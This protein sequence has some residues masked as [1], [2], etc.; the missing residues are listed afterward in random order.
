MIH[1]LC[2]RFSKTGFNRLKLSWLLAILFFGVAFSTSSQALP[3]GFYRSVGGGANYQE[4]ESKNF[5]LYF[6]PKT[7]NEAKSLLQAFEA[8]RPVYEKWFGKRRKSK[9]PVILSAETQSASFANFIFDNIELQTLGRGSRDLAW[10]E[11]AHAMTY[12]YFSN[13]LGHAGAILHLLWLP[14]WFLEGLAEAMSV[15]VGSDVQSGLERYYALSGNWL[16]YNEL[17]RLYSGTNVFSG[18]A[19]SG[20]FVSYLIRRL[21]N[22]KLGH[23][24]KDFAEFSALWQWPYSAIP[25]VDSM[26]MDRVLLKYLGKNGA[27]LYEEYKAAAEKYWKSQ[28]P[29]DRLSESKILLQPHDL[30]ENDFS[31][32]FNLRSTPDGRSQILRYLDGDLYLGEVKKTNNA[33]FVPEFNAL[34][35][36]APEAVDSFSDKTGEWTL[37]NE[38]TFDQLRSLAL[39]QRRPD[40][41]WKEIL[42]RPTQGLQFW[43]QGISVGWVEAEYEK[44]RFCFFRKNLLENT[45]N[46]GVLCPIEAS[47]PETLEYIGTTGTKK[48]L[49]IWIKS[50][51]ETI[52]GNKYKL[53]TW[54]PIRRE[55]NEIAFLPGSGNP[56]KVDNWG[57]GFIFLVAEKKGRNFFTFDEIMTCSS[58]TEPFPFILDFSAQDA[59]QLIYLAFEGKKRPLRQARLED[60]G[61]SL[62]C[63]ATTG[64]L[65]PLLLALSTKTTPPLSWAFA[66]ANP[67][68]LPSA[69]LAKTE[70]RL[71]AKR[72]GA[73]SLDLT[74]NKKGMAL[75][76]PTPAKTRFRPAFAVPWLDADSGGSRLGI[77]SVPLIDEMQNET[78]RIH[79][80]YG[81]GSRFPHLAL[82]ASTSRYWP[83]YSLDLFRYQVW[84]GQGL[85][86][87]SGEIFS[88]YADEKG[89]SAQTSFSLIPF[90]STLAFSWT[91]SFIKSYI[92]NSR[93]GHLNELGINYTYA[94]SSGRWGRNFSLSQHFTPQLVNDIFEYQKFGYSLGISRRNIFLKSQFTLALRGGKTEGD[95][96]RE[97]KESYQPLQTYVP[98]ASTGY[99]NLSFPLLL[100]DRG[101]FKTRYGSNQGRLA[102]TFDFPLVEDLDW[103]VR[104]FY[105]S[106]LNFKSFFSY[107]GAW[108][109]SYDSLTPKTDLIFS[110]SYAADLNFDV[111]GVHFSAGEGVGQVLGQPMEVFMTFSFDAIF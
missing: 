66:Q 100:A 40:G 12:L 77:L 80:G 33:A 39:A 91:S 23:F 5:R 90:H 32:S 49:R 92:G 1:R 15:S 83:I 13:V 89:I 76:P 34:V 73:P 4:I 8:A 44:T 97:L 84:D 14:S 31:D 67:W 9:I 107:G 51:Q 22:K 42:K 108:S 65:S 96:T 74:R 2:F 62:P 50:T 72:I 64:H 11:Q 29:K 7:S 27:E 53:I 68:R 54:D 26:P 18:Y 56:L 101:L 55:K 78:V 24:L 58:K 102:S 81:L 98:G 70:V 47:T 38:D 28:A 3:I 75:A 99:N 60:L 45:K 43:D 36:L 19:S 41:E 82:S 6:H 104:I 105:L 69:A 59:G 30:E 94:S 103:L 57:K 16:T 93:E 109:G 17:H 35:E 86:P 110:H 111:K 71:E 10:H 95:K 106:S 37:K 21:G 48:N 63:A 88:R 20:A 79:A 61:K 46:L 52:Y 25:F 85:D 87:D